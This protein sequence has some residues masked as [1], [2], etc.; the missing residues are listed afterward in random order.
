M[1]APAARSFDSP[2][3]PHTT[4]G[5][6]IVDTIIELSANGNS[7]SDHR[8]FALLWMLSENL[9]GFDRC[10]FI[11]GLLPIPYPFKSFNYWN[12]TPIRRFIALRASQEQ[13]LAGV[14][15]VSGYGRYRTS[16]HHIA[17][18]KNTQIQ[19]PDLYKN[20]LLSSYDWT[21]TQIPCTN[22]S[23]NHIMSETTPNGQF[24]AA[25]EKFDEPFADP[26]L[27]LRCHALAISRS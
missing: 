5:Y 4:V 22:T 10:I 21:P 8:E 25:L 23:L 20:W 13:L 2:L 17:R 9:I 27:Y 6:T 3:G 26:R 7:N 24:L 1:S 14:F 18:H 15:S 16:S 11:I 12:V 19:S